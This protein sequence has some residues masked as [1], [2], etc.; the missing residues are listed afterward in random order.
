MCYHFDLPKHLPGSFFLRNLVERRAL[1]FQMVKRD[2]QQRYVGSAAGWIWGLIHPLVLLGSYWFI[3]GYILKL[4]AGKTQAQGHYSLFLFAGMLPWMLFSETLSRSTSSMLD[5]A[6][7]ITK[8]VFPAEIVPI[9]IFLSAMVG[10]LLAVTMLFVAVVLILHQASFSLLL[11]PLCS[12][13]LGLLAVGLSWIS[14]SFQVYLRDTVQVVTV[15]LIFWQWMTPIF[16]EETSF[17]G[18]THLMV[19]LNPITYVV[20]CYRDVLLSAQAPALHDLAVLFAVSSV[21]FIL[22]GLFFRHMK[23]GFADVL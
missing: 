7:L 1:I 22:G 21:A 23:R 4:P 15:I 5:Q 10:H 9:T 11:L 6:S 8:T 14:S 16:I 12:A 18:R 19:V 17:P 2:F 3:F 20:R 13:L